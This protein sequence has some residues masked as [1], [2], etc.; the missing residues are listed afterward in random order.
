[1]IYII[2]PVHN[3]IQY[4]LTCLKSLSSQAYRDYLI[5]V[6]NDGSA[7]GAAKKIADKYPG[8]K[9][10]EGDGQLWWSASTNLGVEYALSLSGS[11][12]DFILT[13][14]NDLVVR[15]NY[16]AD[17]IS[18]AGRFPEYPDRFAGSRY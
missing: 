3:R 11:Q 10:L 17:L 1:M 18:A 5:I 9:V 6:V 12:K 14:N 8:V 16:L 4:T 13:L 7:D 2:I 15:E